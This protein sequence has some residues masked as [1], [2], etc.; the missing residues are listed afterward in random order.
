MKKIYFSVLLFVLTSIS[1]QAQVSNGF[2][3]DS[4]YNKFSSFSITHL[5]YED[6]PDTCFYAVNVYYQ[7]KDPQ[8]HA[9]ERDYT[10]I[11]NYFYEVL[12]LKHN[13]LD[14]VFPT[15]TGG[16]CTPII[17]STPPIEAEVGD[18]ILVRLFVNDSFAT[19]WGVDT[20]AVSKAPRMHLMF[21]Y[22]SIVDY[23]HA[24][25]I[26]YSHCDSIFVRWNSTK[27][28]SNWDT[29]STLIPLPHLYP[30]SKHK[31]YRMDIRAY[32]YGEFQ[33]FH[34]YCN[35]TFN[36][37]PIQHHMYYSLKGPQS[38]DTTVYF[39]FRNDS[40]WVDTTRHFLKVKAA[41]P[42]T[43]LSTIGYAEGIENINAP[44]SAKL[45][46]IVDA[47]GRESK[48]EPNKVFLYLYEDGTVERKIIIKDY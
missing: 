30:N 3:N 10:A 13:T 26:Q 43:P 6:K 41:N 9:W 16:V 4:T 7:Y 24:D 39:T 47:I 48:P 15:Q 2:W 35:D 17:S 33:Q 8:F 27:I 14:T 37:A 46:K 19:G 20:I 5:P 12:S 28:N 34:W 11:H 22:D 29:R 38:F 21:K 32:G 1:T 23:Y 36:S 31:K 40:G 18:T 45:I 25:P 42:H 44:N